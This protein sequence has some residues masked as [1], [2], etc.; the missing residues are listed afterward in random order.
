MLVI[1]SSSTSVSQFQKFIHNYMP[2]SQ[3]RIVTA[4]LDR[5]LAFRHYGCRTPVL[6]VWV[7]ARSVSKFH[8][9]S[10]E[11]LVSEC[12]EHLRETLASESHEH[13][14]DTLALESHEHLHDTLASERHE[15]VRETLASESHE[16]LLDTLASE[17][18]EHLHDTL[19]S[20][21]HEHL[22]DTLASERHEYLRETLASESHEHNFFTWV[23]I[24]RKLWTLICTWNVSI[25][26]SWTCTLNVSIRRAYTFTPVAE[27]VLHKYRWISEV[28]LCLIL[29]AAFQNLFDKFYGRLTE[30]EKQNR[31][32]QNRGSGTYCYL[33]FCG[34]F[35]SW[36]RTENGTWKYI[37]TVSI[38]NT[39]SICCINEEPQFW[40]LFWVCLF[41]TV[42][43]I[44]KMILKSRW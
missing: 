5:S 19:A 1:R 10:Y 11:T 38:F 6:G 28:D 32:T 41:F 18:H 22:H 34:Q 4:T 23:V 44:I 27:M 36:K 2:L 40:L 42:I 8:V 25:R 43:I 33:G 7:L 16:H 37:L 14:H 39:R 17:I 26:K 29:Q 35:L 24:I 20:E 30:R 31:R 9:Q 21:S 3:V 12:H 13:L 15:Y